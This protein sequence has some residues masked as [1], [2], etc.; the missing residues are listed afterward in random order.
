VGALTIDAQ[1]GLNSGGILTLFGPSGAGKTTIVQMLAGLVRP[2]GGRISLNG[3]VLYDGEARIHVPPEK[4]RIGVIFQEA[5]LFPHLS[6][7]TNLTYGQRL[8]PKDQRYIPFDGLVDTLGIGGLLNRR[9][10]HL[11]GGE[12]QRVALGR[13]LLASP[14][15]LLMDEPLNSVDQDRKAEILEY[16]ARVPE[17]FGVPILYVSHLVD[18]VRR[19][20]PQIIPIQDGR[21]GPVQ[22]LTEREAAA[23]GIFEE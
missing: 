11:S 21:T 1:F 8:V 22:R 23:G 15:L 18:E 10:R 5:R 20:S 4:R 12:K 16:I 14:R 9:P 2:D 7:R 3:A 17:R 6:V 19:L 13:A